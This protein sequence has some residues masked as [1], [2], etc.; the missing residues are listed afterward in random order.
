MRRKAFLLLGVTGALGGCD[1][2]PKDKAAGKPSANEVAEAAASG[3]PDSAAGRRLCAS[4]GTYERLKMLAF[5]EA[6][7]VRGINAAPL[8]ALSRATVVRMERP[9]VL[10]RDEGLGTTVCSGRLVVELPPGAAPQFNGMQRLVADVEYSAQE[11]ADGSG[12]VF[13]MSGAEPIV[14][15]LASFGGMPYSGTAMAQAEPDDLAQDV[16]TP[17]MPPLPPS[18]PAPPPPVSSRPANQPSTP[19]PPQPVPAPPETTPAPTRV[20]P[21]PTR[22]AA[23]PSFNCRYASTPSERAVCADAGLAAKD[24]R[25]SATYFS[26]YERASPE[27]KRQLSRSR[28][29]FLRRRERCS[30]DEC[31][32]DVYDARVAEIRRIAEE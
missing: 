9:L 5:E 30:T 18:P 32:G 27:A 16:R 21:A 10:S 29:E 15:R 17:D 14:F 1:L 11:A 31:I 2:V 20:A 12:P 24:R 7:R 22:Q 13:Q 3:G 28:A 6:R 19:V 25:M 26:A 23:R 4:A 8:D